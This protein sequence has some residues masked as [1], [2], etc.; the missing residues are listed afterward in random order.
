MNG[1]IR[2][3]MLLPCVVRAGAMQALGQLLLMEDCQLLSLG[4]EESHLKELMAVVLNALADNTSLVSIN[5]K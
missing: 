2:C 3:T 4:L 5:I 1:P